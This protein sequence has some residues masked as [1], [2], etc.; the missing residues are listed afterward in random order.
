MSKEEKE[1]TNKQKSKVNNN[2]N[3]K[4]EK[5]EKVKEIKEET[6]SSKKIKEIE[7]KSKMK[8]L[9]KEKTKKD[10]SKVITELDEKRKIIY[11]F[12]GGLLL[13]L[14]IM[15]MF[16]PKRIATLK[17]GQ[18]PIATLNGKNITAD[19]LYTMMKSQYSISILLDKI[20]TDILTELYPEDDELKETVNSTA[21]NYLNQYKQYGY[22]EEQFL[23]QIGVDS[24]S[25]FI[26]YLKLDYRRRQYEDKYIEDN[27]TDKEIEKYYKDN[28]F[29]DINCQHIL[30]TVKSDDD[31]D[32]LTDEE[33]KALAEEIITKINDGT[34][35]DDIKEQYKDKT[36]FED[37]KY[38]SWDA[39]LEESFLN[40]IKEMDENSYS[41]TPTKTSYGYHVIHT[42]DKKEKPTLKEAK[43]TIIEK[44]ITEKKSED[45]NLLYK[46]L[47]ALRKEHKLEFTDTDL[48]DKYKTYCKEYE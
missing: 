3:Q 11:G 34:S 30:V 10:F 40:A 14:L 12:A 45:T 18:E 31:S 35:W 19:E 37:L 47:I 5:V 16:T 7:E 27:L 28:V 6:K 26:E 32:G 4:K 48:E 25:E 36:T 20:D 43:E 9:P 21:E 22:T 13:G 29:G 24:Y 8:K 15:V 2:K 41:K 38:Q 33:A 23:S 46:A 1:K 44:L 39:S 42:L 17:D